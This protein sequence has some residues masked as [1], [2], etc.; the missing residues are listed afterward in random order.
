VCPRDTSLCL[1][2]RG[3]RSGSPP[4]LVRSIAGTASPG[5]EDEDTIWSE[6]WSVSRW[7][8]RPPG[9]C[10]AASVDDYLQPSLTSLATCF[11]FAAASGEGIMITVT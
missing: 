4:G 2:D 3:G 9:P 10:T 1:A 11:G 5:A 6:K 7:E 8:A